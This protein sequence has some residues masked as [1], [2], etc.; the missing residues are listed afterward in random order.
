MRDYLLRKQ[1][2][3]EVLKH[4]VRI[5][6]RI[7]SILLLFVLLVSSLGTTA[8]QISQVSGKITNTDGI[9]L[10]GVTI[11]V[12]GTTTGTI[13]DKNGN[14]TISGL[15]PD[16][17]LVY[18]F[19][20]MQAQ[21]IK[22]KVAK[23]DVILKTDAIGLEEV[24]AVGYGTMKKK[25]LTG[26]ISSIGGET[27]SAIPV[28]SAAEALSGRLAGVQ[29]TTADG[30]PDA[31]VIVR[32]RGGGSITGDNS[33]LY[34]VD[35]FPVSS[36]NDI[37]PTDIESIDVLKD[38]S[39]T[40]IYGSQGANG[41]IIIT[42][43]NAEGGKT[44]VSYNGF[45]QTKSLKNRINVLNPYEYVMSNYEL[46]L[47][48]GENSIK[49]FE[50]RFG[51]YDDFD[52][53]KYQQPTDWQDDMFGA[54][55]LSHQHNISVQ[56]GSPKT[57]YSLS[58][59]YNFNGGLME[60]NDYERFNVNFK[61]S[62]QMYDKLRLELNARISDETT[63][64]SGTS[65]GT[66][67]I[68]TS[69]AITKGPIQGL[70]D[71]IIID[72]NTLTDDEYDQWVKDN[73]T[74]SEQAS[75]YWKRRYS[76]GFA[77]TGAIN[78]D[79]LKNLKY[80]LE[81]GY[82]YRFQEDQNYWGVYTTAASYKGGLPYINLASN[83]TIIARQAQTL[84]YSF[85]KKAHRFD[86]MVGQEINSTLGN[87]YNIEH[88]R[89]AA[90]LSPEK[91]F[92]NLAL[93]EGV[94]SVSSRYL[95]PYN[96]ASFFGRANYIYN[97][98]YYAT[99]T[100]RADGSTKFAKGNQWGNFFAGALAWRINEENW[101]QGAK[102]WL[103][104]L[105][106][107]LSYGEAGNDK[108]GSTQFQLS[109]KINN[110]RVY[111][112]DEQV[113][114]YYSATNAQLP[115][116][117]LRWETTI[118]RNIGIDFGFLDERFSGSFEV[119]QN[120]ADDLLIERDIVA[121]GYETTFENIGATSTKGI[122]LQLNANIIDKKK[123]NLF[124]NLN[125]G[126]YTSKVD[127]LAPG[128]N[129][130]NYSSG[131]AGTDLAGYQDYKIKVGEP[132]GIIYG[133]ETDGYYTTDD[134]KYYNE[135]D[136]YVLKD[137]VAST[138]LIGG[139]PGIRPGVLKLK[140]LSN[141]GVV[142]DK[143]R[144][145]IGNATPKMYGGF[146]I[147]SAFYGFDVSLMFNFVIGNDIYNATKLASTS[148]YRTNNPN[149]QAIMGA[150]NA[151]TYLDRTTGT[152]VTNLDQLKQMNELGEN[153][154]ELWSP[155]SLGNANQIPHSWGIEKGSFLRLQNVTLG[156][157]IPN[158][159]SRKAK[160]ERFRVYCTVNNAWVL[161]NYSGYDP[162]VSSPVRGSSTSA[163]TP[164][165]DYSSYPKSLAWTFGVNIGL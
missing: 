86:L 1:T 78:W 123:W 138:A 163:L 6:S 143:D 100:Y 91:I 105:K 103:S 10:P 159:I 154:K 90:D 149:F 27:L 116:P 34:I 63:N 113:S 17:I 132:I 44:Q 77:F 130:Q 16:A 110:D 83:A 115:N 148:Q 145:K 49:N 74:L 62:H 88:T 22:I 47:L 134:F 73:L 76:K 97:N 121:P 40:A 58:G 111:A 21:E 99:I 70:S 35:G 32:V 68:R 38:A 24:V 30:S 96:R 71:Q 72:P 37:P 69:D 119:Y 153:K 98:K 54:D 125:L 158:Q 20:G 136:G 156:Y 46:A 102:T 144:T 89:Y 85:E 150:D 146:G 161:T 152:L 9:A 79:I 31:E 107:R 80:R 53:Y 137:N 131:C 82:N 36:I 93:G 57:K 124:A 5:Q 126:T 92:A 141:D 117:N 155:W 104:N 67:K 52:L 118:T 51:V 75:Q 120:T 127:R 41:V 33:P 25:D 2:K 3:N 101:M 135:A 64:G 129:E 81:G 45:V 160:I 87:K 140:D 112:L 29:V 65:G 28:P 106:L 164:G 95:D 13:T 19:I 43:K 139:R 61:L 18:S 84:T 133:W 162:E 4:D 108:I 23:Q 39:S 60:N 56:G 151:Y 14:Y 165:V 50:K 59:T 147:N 48:E 55:V 142:D 12:K 42:T 26:S 15:K 128:V 94:P 66:Y 122:E 7:N 11:V 157:T 114:P 109:Y 8:Q